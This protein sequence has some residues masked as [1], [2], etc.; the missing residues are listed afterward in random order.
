MCAIL[1]ST[2]SC[3]VFDFNA[4]REKVLQWQPIHVQCS[5][6]L[7]YS[8]FTGKSTLQLKTLINDVNE[9][10]CLILNPSYWQSDID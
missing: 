9:R 3:C 10:G 2:F 4:M 8:A 6:R 5:V 1:Y 7:Y